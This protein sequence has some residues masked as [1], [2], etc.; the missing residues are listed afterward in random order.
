M[1]KL[2]LHSMRVQRYSVNF[3]HKLL[4]GVLKSVD[5]WLRKC[6]KSRAFLLRCRACL[7]RPLLLTLF[8][9]TKKY[10]HLSSSDR[11]II[12]SQGNPAVDLHWTR[13]GDDDRATFRRKWLSRGFSAAWA[14]SSPSLFP[15]ELSKHSSSQIYSLRRNCTSRSHEH[16]NWGHTW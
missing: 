9:I 7:P 3:H 1:N 4:E 12:I 10:P 16:V 5:L 11:T 13:D 15:N 2:H 6:V 8:R 14:P